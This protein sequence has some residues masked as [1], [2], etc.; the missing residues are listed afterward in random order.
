MLLPPPVPDPTPAGPTDLS[1][2]GSANCYIVSKAGSYSFKAVKGN[3]TESVGDVALATVLW[4]SFGTSVQPTVGSLIAEVSVSTETGFVTFSTPETLENGNALIA[5]KDAYNKILWSWHIWLCN[6][7]DALASAQVYF[8]EAGTM[9]DRNLGATSATPGTVGALGLLY[10][11]GRKDP[12]IGSSNINDLRRAESTSEFSHTA[13]TA[14]TGTLEYATQHPET[15]LTSNADWLNTANDNLWKS[16][17]TIYDPCPPSWCVPSGE[18]YNQSIWMKAKDTSKPIYEFDMDLKG[19]DFT[20]KFGNA[21]SIW[22]PCAGCMNNTSGDLNYVG[23][24]GCWWSY[25]LSG[26][27]S[28]CAQID[29]EYLG[30]DMIIIPD[31]RA[32]G[33]SVRCCRE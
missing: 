16:V 33:L 32:S 12:F 7:Y 11:W 10:Q 9:M 4:E 1:A 25:T 21:A 31:K 5:V 3:S 22:Y 19:I 20:Q 14:T 15:F 28:A 30:S 24:V 2:A 27:F 6:G 26:T 8:N 17:K 29:Y 13:S 18:G 23:E